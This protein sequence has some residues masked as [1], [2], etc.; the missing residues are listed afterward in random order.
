MP[1]EYDVFVSYRRHAEW[2][3]WV[4][5]IFLPL[6]NHWLTH[7]RVCRL[8]LS[9]AILPTRG[10]CVEHMPALSGI[11]SAQNQPAQFLPGKSR[12]RTRPPV[13]A[14]DPRKG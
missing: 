2:P 6:F 12:S 11:A 13:L 5:S 14:G 1:Y 7:P 3:K 4:Q 8:L 9:L 10:L